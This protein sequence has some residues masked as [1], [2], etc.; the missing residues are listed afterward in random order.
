MVT[1]TR[2][3]LRNILLT[4]SHVTDDFTCELVL[5]SKSQP[6]VVLTGDSLSPEKRA[7]FQAKLVSTANQHIDSI[8][9]ELAKELS[10]PAVSS[11][12]YELLTEVA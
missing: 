7:S 2:D 10:R 11:K 5:K 6:E 1:D 9:E 3:K 4:L 8:R 12:L